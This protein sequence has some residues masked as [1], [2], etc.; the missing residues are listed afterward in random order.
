MRMEKAV[1]QSTFHLMA[2]LYFFVRSLLLEMRKPK[3][4]QGV[5]YMYRA[6]HHWVACLAIYSILVQVKLVV[7]HH[8]GAK[9]AAELK[10]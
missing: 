7:T 8:L 2:L 9:V 6:Q 5:K 4:I 3:E 1:S 10:G